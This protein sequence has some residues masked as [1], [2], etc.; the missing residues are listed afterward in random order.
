[1][2]IAGTAASRAGVVAHVAEAP[3]DVVLLDV[4]MPESLETVRALAAAP[5]PV[6]TVVF[7]VSD[8]DADLL[9]CAEAGVAGYVPRDGSLQDLVA[10]LESVARGEVLCSP[11]LAAALFRRVAA[12]AAGR[13]AA[14]ADPAGELLTPRERE[15][16]EL[17]D[18]G[19]SNKEIASRLSI[20]SATVKNHVHNLLEKLGAT[21]RGEAAARVRTMARGA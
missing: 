11:R 5:T 9:A 17:I 4:A 15:I 10:T 14:P 18:L 7:A 6:K 13:P 8:S 2:R 21:R 19:L 12:L 16:V 20:G 1:V 3:P